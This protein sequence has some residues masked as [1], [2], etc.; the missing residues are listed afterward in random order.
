MLVDDIP[1]LFTFF[2]V[3]NPNTGKKISGVFL[4][5]EYDFFQE[6][7]KRNNPVKNVKYVVLANGKKYNVFKLA[8][9]CIELWI[10]FFKEN[11]LL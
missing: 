7:L 1:V 3:E 6:V 2:L 5:R 10:N 8:D 4:L 9:R 11:N